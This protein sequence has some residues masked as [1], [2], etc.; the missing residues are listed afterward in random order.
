MADISTAVSAAR[1]KAT[2]PRRGSGGSI[3][4]P[5]GSTSSSLS[6][7]IAGAVAAARAVRSVFQKKWKSERH[8]LLFKPLGVDIG[9]EVHQWDSAGGK[10]VVPVYRV[11]RVNVS[12][13]ELQVT[14]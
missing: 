7:G 10:A 12:V 11:R 2:N 4:G 1:N 8:A 6:P 9:V 3:P 14:Y 5:A 13:G